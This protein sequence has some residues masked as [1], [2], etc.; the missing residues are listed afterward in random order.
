MVL[1][2]L[3]VTKIQIYPTPKSKGNE[4]KERAENRPQY[5]NHLKRLHWIK[6]WS[7]QKTIY[8]RLIRLNKTQVLIITTGNAKQETGKLDRGNI[9]ARQNKSPPKKPRHNDPYWSHKK[10]KPT[11]KYYKHTVGN[12]GNFMYNYI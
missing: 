8:N 12:V 2:L 1:L 3:K 5:G 7:K 11:S 6:N 4:K 10:K 9:K